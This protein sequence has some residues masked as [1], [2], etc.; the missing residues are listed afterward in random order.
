LGG[1]A[2]AVKEVKEVK[3]GQDSALAESSLPFKALQ[4]E[5]Q[6]GDGVSVQATEPHPH[7]DPP[8]EGEEESYCAHAV[9]F[10]H[11]V[12]AL[13]TFF[14]SSNFFTSFTSF[15]SFTQNQ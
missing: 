12:N 8:L 1:E 4:G 5:G 13:T 9:S 6:G 15:T 7:L 14:T 2:E 11:I 10:C 3:E